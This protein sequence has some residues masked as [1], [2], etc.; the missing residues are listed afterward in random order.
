[1]LK[2]SNWRSIIHNPNLIPRFSSIVKLKT[3]FS[4]S[5]FSPGGY[6]LCDFRDRLHDWLFNMPRPD[7][8]SGPPNRCLSKEMN[9][10]GGWRHTVYPSPLAAPYPGDE[11]LPAPTKC[12]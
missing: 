8:F 6:Y 1:M 12:A 10:S 3:V 7:P 5:L 9:R 11:M 4:C 2:L